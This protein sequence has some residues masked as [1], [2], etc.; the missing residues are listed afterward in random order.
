MCVHTAQRL[1]VPPD[2]GVSV[3]MQYLYVQI[4]TVC[5]C[6]CICICQCIPL[7]MWCGVGGWGRVTSIPYGGGGREHETRD[8]TLSMYVCMDGWMDVC[9]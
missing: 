7:W 2:M 9:M 6:I 3:R 1:V 4:Y 8:H 5:I